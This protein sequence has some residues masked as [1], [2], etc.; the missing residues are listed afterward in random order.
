M[1]WE[2]FRDQI[3]LPLVDGVR[4][5]LVAPTPELRETINHVR[6]TGILT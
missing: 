6:F 1:K 2:T 4:T 5:L 3:W